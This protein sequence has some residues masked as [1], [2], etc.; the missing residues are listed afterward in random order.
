MANVSAMAFKATGGNTSRA[1]GDRFAETVNVKDFGATGSGSV[2]DKAAIQAALDFAYGPPGA[3]HGG[4]STG[5]PLNRRIFFPNGT[6]NISGPLMLNEV[7]GGSIGGAGK[8]ATRIVNTATSGALYY[9]TVFLTSIN[10]TSF[11]LAE[12]MTVVA[13][14][15]G[16]GTANRGFNL[17][18][19]GPGHGNAA[20]HQH[21]YRNVRFEGGDHGIGIGDGGNM[22]SEIT[23]LGCDFV[24]CAIGMT[25]FN[26]NALDFTVIGCSFQNC[27]TGV[28]CNSTSTFSYFN[29]CS[30]SGSTNY[31][32][33]FDS[34]DG[35]V[36]EACNSTS[37]TFLYLL[38]SVPIHTKACAHAPAPTGNYAICQ[39]WL[40]MDGCM[41]TNAVLQQAGV[42]IAG[43]ALY[44]RG[45]ALPGNFISGSASVP[46]I[47][48][49]I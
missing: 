13:A 37:P 43:N 46:T 31:D 24:G 44:M 15:P 18:W 6:Y 35:M 45:N 10:G 1:L 32:I 27:G 33:R 41:V 7:F 25:A 5:F 29:G 9:G 39:A 16:T 3:P 19:A 8:H 49:N 48:E 47:P 22:G 11:F 26:F 20:L 2:D 30:F 38:G 12:N 4:L 40:I 21:T 17:A 42:A 14:A 36:V 23:F 34:F 28:A